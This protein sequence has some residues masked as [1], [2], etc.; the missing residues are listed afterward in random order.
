MLKFNGFPEAIK[1]LT[2]SLFKVLSVLYRYLALHGYLAVPYPK[3][4]IM[5]QYCQSL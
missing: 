3:L 1:S 2:M 5:L 4:N